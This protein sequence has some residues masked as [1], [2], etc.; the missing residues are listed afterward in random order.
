MLE[1]LSD[2]AENEETD[3]VD[4]ESADLG[5]EGVDV[6]DADGNDEDNVGDHDS[7]HQQARL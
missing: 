1:D 4:I 7:D 2:L 5:G 6:D 3:A